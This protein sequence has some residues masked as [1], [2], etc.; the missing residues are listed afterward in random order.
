MTKVVLTDAQVVA[1]LEA[2]ER[3]SQLCDSSGRVVGYYRARPLSEFWDDMKRK[4]PEKFA[5]PRRGGR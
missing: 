2:I 1:A 3:S 4:Y 5:E